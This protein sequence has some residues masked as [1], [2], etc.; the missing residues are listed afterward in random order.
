MHYCV[1]SFTF[2]AA[3]SSC[4]TSVF[5]QLKYFLAFFALNTRMQCH[6]LSLGCTIMSFPPWHL[7]S[8][9]KFNFCFCQWRLTL[10]LIA[11]LCFSHIFFLRRHYISD[12]LSVFLL[13]C[14][15]YHFLSVTTC[16]TAHC[17]FVNLRVSPGL[18]LCLCW[19]LYLFLRFHQIIIRHGV[20]LQLIAS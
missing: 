4:D 13:I 2:L 3:F 16:A 7:A 1:L 14:L 5:L 15:Q 8:S 9:L 12:R 19:C 11:S 20:A 17:F 18:C 6:V 10:Q